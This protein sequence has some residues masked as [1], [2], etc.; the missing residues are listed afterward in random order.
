MVN[1]LVGN[2]M[3]YTRLI[4]FEVWY[5]TRKWASLWNLLEVV[6]LL[7]MLIL[8]PQFK[9]TESEILKPGICVLISLY[10]SDAL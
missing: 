9:S 7:E 10:D 5:L 6:R 4:I 8:E 1:F 3:Y 2:K